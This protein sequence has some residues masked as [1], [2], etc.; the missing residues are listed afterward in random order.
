MFYI[1]FSANY[2]VDRGRATRRVKKCQ[3]IA[4]MTLARNYFRNIGNIGIIR[5]RPVAATASYAITT[6]R[7][8]SLIGTKHA[9]TLDAL[10]PAGLY[11]PSN[12]CYGPYL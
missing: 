8:I 7:S 6:S 11:H 3:D 10:W 5:I 4:M 12:L 2:V 1:S 9:I